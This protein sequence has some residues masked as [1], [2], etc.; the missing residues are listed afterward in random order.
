MPQFD[1]SFYPSQ[2]FWLFISFGFLYLM[3]RYLICP[4]IEGV[5]TARESGLQQVLKEA[6]EMN[7]QAA[8]FQKQYQAFLVKTEQE[9]SEKIQKASQDIQ[10]KIR[11]L[12]RKNEKHL[13]EQVRRAEQK[14]ERLTANLEHETEDL[15]KELA[16]QLVDRI[17]QKGTLS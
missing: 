1:L 6:E 11:A 3:M 2:I 14:I 4:K 12:E 5:L 16:G 7:K 15:S 9:K 13:L 8:D 10:R 17:E